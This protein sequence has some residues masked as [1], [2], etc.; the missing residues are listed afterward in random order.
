[1]PKQRQSPI[2]LSPQQQA[3]SLRKRGEN[4]REI[5]ANSKDPTARV[6]LIRRAEIWESKAAEIERTPSQTEQSA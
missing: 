5:A 6:V 2:I 3:A 1:M 4:L